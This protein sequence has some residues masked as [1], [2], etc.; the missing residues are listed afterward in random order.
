MERTSGYCKVNMC[1]QVCGDVGARKYEWTRPV[2]GSKIFILCSDCQKL[3]D[4]AIDNATD[5]VKRV[6]TQDFDLEY[7]KIVNNRLA[8]KNQLKLNV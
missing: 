8:S 4:V 5:K 3:I 7:R 1:C 6:V 2:A